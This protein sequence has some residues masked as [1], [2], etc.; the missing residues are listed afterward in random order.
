M[1]SWSIGGLSQRLPASVL[2]GHLGGDKTT[3]LKYLIQQ[4]ALNRMRVLGLA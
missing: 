3:V 2:T 4:P 1:E